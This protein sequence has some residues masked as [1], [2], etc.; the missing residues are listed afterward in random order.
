[1]PAKNFSN[2]R[3]LQAFNRQAAKLFGQLYAPRASERQKY[4]VERF[5]SEGAQRSRFGTTEEM[6][7]RLGYYS[8]LK[9]ET[10]LRE[11]WANTWVGSRHHLWARAAHELT[12]ALSLSR[13]EFVVANALENYFYHIYA[14]PGT[15]NIIAKVEPIVPHRSIALIIQESFEARRVKDAAN[16]A[17]IAGPK[18]GR[19]SR[20]EHHTRNRG[21]TYHTI[22][23]ELGL[24]AAKAEAMHGKP[25]VGLIFIREV[26]EGKPVGVV[27][28]EVELGLHDKEAEQLLND[29]PFFARLANG[30]IRRRHKRI[31]MHREIKR[32]NPATPKG[33]A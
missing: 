30:K 12:H 28:K 2:D 27:A 14:R 15:L 11:D 26:S 6:K 21:Y 23:N 8:P 20:L 1:M 5:V 7:N 24:I 17:L 19:S 16:R 31:T 22:G 9:N 29:N 25:G 3:R 33:N 32:A 4:R 18:S 10:V 13:N